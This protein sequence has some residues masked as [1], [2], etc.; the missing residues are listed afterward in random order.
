M[1]MWRWFRAGSHLAT[2]LY[3]GVIAFFKGKNGPFGTTPQ[4]VRDQDPFNFVLLDYSSH[5]AKLLAVVSKKKIA[6]IRKKKFF[7]LTLAF[8]ILR[9]SFAQSLKK[10]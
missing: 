3:V 5:H 10:N 4:G 7:F 6:L 1:G 2:P 8:R 9:F